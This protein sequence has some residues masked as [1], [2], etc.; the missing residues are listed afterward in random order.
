MENCCCINTICNLGDLKDSIINIARRELKKMVDK[1]VEEIRPTYETDP[2]Y[3]K[4]LELVK[5]RKEIFK[6]LN[7][8]DK[9]L[10]SIVGEAYSYYDEEKDLIRYMSNIY[11]KQM[12]LFDVITDTIE[13]ETS[14]PGNNPHYILSIIENKIK[15]E[16]SSIK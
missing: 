10:N 6:Q 11:K 9:E 3:V 12:E 14:I 15:D 5:K 1:K 16:F 7:A 4:A 8:V 2:Q 13:I